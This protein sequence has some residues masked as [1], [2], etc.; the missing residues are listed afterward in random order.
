MIKK[1]IYS[2][3]LIHTPNHNYKMNSSKKYCYGDD[4]HSI[5]GVDI[6]YYSEYCKLDNFFF[7]YIFNSEDLN[8]CVEFAPDE[9]VIHSTK[10]LNNKQIIEAFETYIVNKI[11]NTYLHLN[12][13]YLDIKDAL[14]KEELELE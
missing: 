11:K 10:K 8:K 13:I 5:D 2:Y 1:L 12:E 6:D 14:D 7:G 3:V 9:Y 4:E